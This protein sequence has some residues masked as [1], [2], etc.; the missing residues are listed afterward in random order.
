[1]ASL[2]SS[3]IIFRPYRSPYCDVLQLHN[4]HCFRRTIVGLKKVSNRGL[5]TPKDTSL[6]QN[7]ESKCDCASNIIRLVVVVGVI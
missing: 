1:M 6:T 4:N 5:H 7:R 2:C 3:P